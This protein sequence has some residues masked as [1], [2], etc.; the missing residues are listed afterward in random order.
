MS[1]FV[2]ATST[3]GKHRIPLCN[4][5]AFQA[6]E[7]YVLVHTMAHK[8][9]F[10]TE[11][12]E[13]ERFSRVMHLVSQVEGR[14]REDT[15]PLEAL[16]ASFPAGTVSGAPKV[17]AMERIEELEASPRGP[18][19]GALVFLDPCGDL[20]SCIAL[21]TLLHRDGVVEVRTGAGVVADST[22]EGELAETGHKA[23]ALLR[24]LRAAAGEE[25]VR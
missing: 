10:L 11:L 19:A 9:L 1:V 21:R 22:P 14:L 2:I 17:R 23:E 12:M 6:D 4:V 24:A 7:K 8:T 25:V 16:A 13:T 5:I 18:Y 3:T 20:D 15:S